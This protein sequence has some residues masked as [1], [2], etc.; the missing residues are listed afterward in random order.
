LLFPFH[1][2]LPYVIA[3]DQHVASKQNRQDRAYLEAAVV[4]VSVI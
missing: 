4:F 3:D 2:N 1:F